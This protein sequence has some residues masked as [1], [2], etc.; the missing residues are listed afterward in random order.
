M[1]C[2]LTLGAFLMSWGMPL[3]NP[4]VLPHDMRVLHGLPLEAIPQDVGACE[5]HVSGPSSPPGACHG[6]VPGALPRHL[7]AY[8]GLALG[9]FCG[10]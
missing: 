8:H 10:T 1:P 9:S 6:F 3:P 2:A 7:G 4:R 5:G